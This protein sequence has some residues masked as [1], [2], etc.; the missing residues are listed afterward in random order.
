MN[1]IEIKIS[2]LKFLQRLIHGKLDPLGVCMAAPEFG[3]NENILSL[4][5]AIAFGNC[6]FDALSDFSLVLVNLC[7][8]QMFIASLEGRLDGLFGFIGAFGQPCS[9]A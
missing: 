8:I 9:Q 4:Q 6:L 2:K 3:G 5:F 7:E 1:E